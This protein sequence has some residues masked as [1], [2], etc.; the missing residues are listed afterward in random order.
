MAVTAPGVAYAQLPNKSTTPLVPRWIT[1][2]TMVG[3]LGGTESWFTPA[4]RPYSHFGVGGF[5]AIRQWQ[6]L[7]YRA[8]SDLQGNPYSIS[9]EC[10]DTG[11][12]FPVWSRSNVPRFTT[13]QADALVVL[14]SWLCHRF[15]LPKQA[16]RS[17]CPDERGIGWHRFGIDPWRQT[18]CLRWS[19]SAG[20]ACPGDRRIAQL[21]AEIIPRVSSPEDTMTPAQEAKVDRVLASLTRIE[22]EHFPLVAKVK[23]LE[24][25]FELM[26]PFGTEWI[27][28]EGA[29]GTAGQDGHVEALPQDRWLIEAV[30]ILRQLKADT[31]PE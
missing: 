31:R 3:T 9:I 26:A 14:L 16:I 28:R 8:A 21:Q 17:S 19:S 20:K 15:G 13:S 5:G 24:H 22:N 1:I 23:R 29:K 27:N 7:R 6:D 11:Y 2:H 25:L 12:P 10:E 4:G 18:N 30:R